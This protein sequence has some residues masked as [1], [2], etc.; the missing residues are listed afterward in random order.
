MKTNVSGEAKTTIKFWWNKQDF[1][2]KN[3]T[4]FA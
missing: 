4:L 3:V 2:R 1:I